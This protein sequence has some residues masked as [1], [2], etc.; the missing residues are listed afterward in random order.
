MADPNLIIFSTP[1]VGDS[2]LTASP[3]ATYVF[4][5]REYRPPLQP[6]ASE[7]D[8]VINQNGTFKYNYDNG[9]GPYRW[10]P[11]ELV[12][13]DKFAKRLAYAVG[14]TTPISATMQWNAFQALWNHFGPK[15]MRAPEDVY[16]V[17]FPSQELERQFIQFPRAVGDKIE[18]TV[19]I[20][21]EEA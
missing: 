21:V 18:Y 5:S 17:M 14:T 3:A 11:F 20:Q 15:N 12:F 6:R 16:S 2:T 9:P 4:F 8:I 1:T 10:R 19:A 7:Q 13:D